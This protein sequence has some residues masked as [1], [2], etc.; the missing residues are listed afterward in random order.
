MTV[1]T[2]NVQIQAS[3]L[4]ETTG[5]AGLKRRKLRIDIALLTWSS[6]MNRYIPKRRVQTDVYAVLQV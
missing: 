5:V 3:L 6:A 2:I 4:Y 1:N